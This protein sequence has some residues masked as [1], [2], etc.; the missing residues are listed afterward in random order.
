[1]RRIGLLFVA[2]SLVAVTG[3]EVT[4]EGEIWVD[5]CL[6]TCLPGQV[7]W[8]G[9]CYDQAECVA[10]YDIC[11]F[12]D[13]SA[14]CTDLASDPFNCGDCGAFCDGICSL[15]ACYA[16]DYSCEEQNLVTCFDTYCSD[17]N[18]VLDCG[19]CGIECA[20]D[21]VC[22]AGGCVGA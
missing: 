5:D 14:G 18:N 9:A 16:A 22:V 6:G 8:D 3:C 11:E 7:C 10:P 15:G 2:L 13:G 20:L 19:D 12:E 17:L 1:M 21:E 4:T